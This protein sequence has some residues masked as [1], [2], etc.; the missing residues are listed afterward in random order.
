ML[1]TVDFP[2]L[3]HFDG[4]YLDSAAMAQM[5]ANTVHALKARMSH[6]LR[7]NVR[8]NLSVFGENTDEEFESSRTFFASILGVQSQAISFCDRTTLGLNHLALSLGRHGFQSTTPLPTEIWATA[9]E[10][11]ANY[12]PWMA[13]AHQLRL[14]FIT[15]PLT[16]GT[17][18]PDVSWMSER[19]RTHGAPHLLAI[20]HVSNVTGGLVELA[21]IRSIVGQHTLLV[22]DGAQAVPHLS[23]MPPPV[24]DA[25]A[26]SGYKFGG[27]TGTGVLALSPRLQ[28]LRPTF[29]GGG[30][31][32]SVTDTAFSPKPY[33]HGWEAGTPALDG[34]ITLPTAYQ[35]W[36]A[37]FSEKK[38]NPLRQHLVDVLQRMPRVQVLAPEL[39]ADNSVGVLSFLVDGVHPHDIGSFLAEHRV[40]V[41]VGHHCAQPLATALGISGSV[42][43]SF[44]PYTCER[45]IDKLM[46]AL[47]LVLKF[48]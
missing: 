25:Y 10:H 37:S 44:G 43:V 35:S 18:L 30:M 21:E 47:A 36:H 16:P 26:F 45:D 40:V 22:V 41:R 12:L 6:T 1:S 32:G 14:K 27:L 31:V 20:T 8:R 13:L 9:L 4:A 17:L 48:F 39:T 34:I 42:R 33:P 19:A 2:S 5:H 7:T 15:V 29:F 24:F 11:H 3:V 38:E 28:S 23:K 46:Q